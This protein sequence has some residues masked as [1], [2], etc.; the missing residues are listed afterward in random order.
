[1]QARKALALLLSSTSALQLLCFLVGL[2]FELRGSC[3]QG[4]TLLL[5]SSRA[6]F[7]LFVCFQ[8]FLKDVRSSSAGHWWLMPVI[9]ATKEAEI[10]RILVWSQPEQTVE[11]L[12]LEKSQHQ[13]RKDKKK[14]HPTQK[15]TGGVAQGSS[16]CLASMRSWIQAPVLQKQT[17]TWEV[18]EG[19]KLNP[20]EGK[21]TSGR[22]EVWLKCYSACFTSAKPWVQTPVPWDTSGLCL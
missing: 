11:R 5:A 21:T 19:R 20:T 2:G 18:Y 22:L 16:A 6:S 9:L 8:G 1:V 3:L 4:G 13:K 15:R 10:R 14:K 17:K 7:C 12:Y